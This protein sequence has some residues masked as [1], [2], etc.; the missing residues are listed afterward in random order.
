MD[1][2]TCDLLLKSRL[3][4]DEERINNNIMIGAKSALKVVQFYAGSRKAS[5]LDFVD[6]KIHIIDDADSDRE[7][8]LYRSQYNLLK[9]N[10]IDPIKFILQKEQEELQ[11]GK[12]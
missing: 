10:N 8:K 9:S 3:K 1:Y 2:R 6:Y 7:I 11:N 4:A 12:K 5:E